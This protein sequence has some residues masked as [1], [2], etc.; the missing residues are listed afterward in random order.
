MIGAT[1]TNLS[2][3]TSNPQM[4]TVFGQWLA[5][6]NHVNGVDVSDAEMAVL[7]KGFME[8]SRDERLTFASPQLFADV[9]ALAEVRQGK[10]FRAIELDSAT[11]ADRFLRQ[12][13]ADGSVMALADGVGIKILQAGDKAHPKPQQTVKVHYFARLLNGSEVTEFGPDDLI[14]V[15][16]HLNVGLFEGFQQVGKRGKLQLFLP[17]ALAVHQVEMADAPRGSALICEIEML[18]IG[19][20]PPDDLAAALVPP[21]PESPP[22]G[23]SGNFPTNQVIEAWGWQLAQQG[24]LPKMA[25]NED[26][27]AAVAK[28]FEAGVR[29]EPVLFDAAKIQAMDAFVNERR[30]EFV[31][32]FKRKQVADMETLFAK[33]K[34]NTNVVTLPDGLRYEIVKPG[35]GIHPKPGQIV[36]VNYTGSLINGHVFDQT[37]VEPLHVTVGRV[38]PGWS[39]GIQKIGKGGKLRLYIPPSLGYGGDAV[40]GIPADSTLIYDIE[41]LDIQNA[42]GE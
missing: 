36:L 29:G 32:A 19:D 14:L 4:A 40:S 15:T 23:Y 27:C 22:P 24:H 42:D 21:A 8:G 26:E 3:A 2:P 35:E 37:T 11:T 38:I 12:W 10:V 31:Q 28:G 9:R 16:N 13:K 20:T 30:Q 39:E 6:N 17:P 1:E 41:L 18:G 34:E 33:L 7:M 25:L 5:R